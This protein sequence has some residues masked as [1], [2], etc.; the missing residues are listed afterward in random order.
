MRILGRCDTVDGS[1]GVGSA[2]EIASF[3]GC[4][5]LVFDG[6]LRSVEGCFSQ[7]P[8]FGGGGKAVPV[9]AL[10]WGTF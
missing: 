5:L 6:E 1:S 4:A 2:E 3:V 7:G 8:F 10:F 9:R